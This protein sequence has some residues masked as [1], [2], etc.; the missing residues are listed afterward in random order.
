MLLHILDLKLQKNQI[1]VTLLIGHSAL[2][3]LYAPTVRDRGGPARPIEASEGARC[4]TAG[5]F[6][7]CHPICLSAWPY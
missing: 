7:V 4:S 1:H 6:R 5:V 3:E 2:L